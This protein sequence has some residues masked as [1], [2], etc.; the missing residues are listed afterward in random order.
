MSHDIQFLPDMT[1][2]EA[3]TKHTELKSLESVMRSMLLEMRDRKGW[4]ALGFSS[5]AEY[6]EKEWN[7]SLSQLDRLATAA[8]I[9]SFLPPIGGLQIPESQLRPLTS[10]PDEAKPEVWQE[11]ITRALAEGKKIGAKYV[12]DVANEWKLKNDTLQISL[13]E[14]TK[15]LDFKQITLNAVKQQSDDL[16]NSIAA[17]I[18]AGVSEQLATERANLILENSSA[19]QQA[20]RKALDAQDA[21]EKLKKEQAKAIKDG[22]T[23]DLNA[24]KIEIDQLEYRIES[25]QKQE[26]DLK[27]SRDLLNHENGVIK[28]HQDSIST[29]V[30]AIHDIKG[31]LYLADESGNAPVELINEWAEISYAMSQLSRQFVDFCNQGNTF[32]ANGVVMQSNANLV[33]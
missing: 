12:E 29:I 3:R 27:Q 7:Y 15:K 11:A 14:T 5:W 4:R 2:E 33:E 16:R 22:V 18:T 30:E 9:E 17:Q 19:I 32:D 21:L 1:P 10:I 20:Q 8:R 28:Q 31:A 26:T 25:L 13:I 23:K 6:G 24:K